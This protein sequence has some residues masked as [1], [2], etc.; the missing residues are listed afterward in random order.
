[1]G[2]LTGLLSAISGEAPNTPGTHRWRRAVSELLDAVLA[3]PSY[4]LAARETSVQVIADLAAATDIVLNASVNS[5]GSAISFNPATGFFSLLEPGLYDLDARIGF[6][7]FDTAASDIAQFVWRDSTG[8]D[9][10]NGS[11]GSSVPATSTQNIAPQPTVKAYVEVT[12]VPRNV[13]PVSVGGQ[14]GADVSVGS[15]ASVRKIG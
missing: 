10:A 8:T 14:G 15:F 13:I 12:T 4:V 5:H 1:M 3:S 7:G 6:E 9:L 2:L 11:L